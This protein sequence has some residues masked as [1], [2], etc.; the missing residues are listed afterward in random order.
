MNLQRQ[1][2][3]SLWSRIWDE[4][5]HENDPDGYSP[6]FLVCIVSLVIWLA[7]LMGGTK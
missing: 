5:A 4:L 6:P 1:A 2:H 3:G 7:E